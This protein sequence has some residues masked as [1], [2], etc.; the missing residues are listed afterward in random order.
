M[1]NN[2]RRKDPEDGLPL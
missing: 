1:L 2:F